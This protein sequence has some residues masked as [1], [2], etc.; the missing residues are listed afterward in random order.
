MDTYLT[1]VVDYL[2]N[3]SWQIVILTVLVAF[4]TFLLRNRSAHIRYLLWL[5]VL[6]KCLMPPLYA[7]PVRVLPQDLF[8][9]WL[10]GS[11]SNDTGIEAEIAA[12][13]T[14]DPQ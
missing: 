5:I 3:Q 13:T 6:V 14:D 10:S 8:A 9:G 7:V 2:L 4:V 12:A 11:E 1:Q